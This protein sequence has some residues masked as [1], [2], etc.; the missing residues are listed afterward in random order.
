MALTDI[1]SIFDFGGGGGGGG[2]GSFDEF[3]DFLQT[4]QKDLEELTER[5]RLQ[6]TEFASLRRGEI[7][8]RPGF[9]G[10]VNVGEAVQRTDIT[11]AADISALAEDDPQRLAFQEATAGEAA[12]RAR[13]TRVITGEQF[14]AE[15]ALAALREDL[16]DATTQKDVDKITAG[17]EEFQEQF[18]FFEDDSLLGDIEKRLEELD[19]KSPEET[20]RRRRERRRREIAREG[21]EGSSDD[22]STGLEGF[23]L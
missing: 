6:A 13:Q 4:Q 15:D 21:E 22:Q 9:A 7:A 17:F 16:E 18:E 10:L 19:A 2:S 12:T 1:L 23:V 3:L 5:E 20:F 8:D 14:E 11:L